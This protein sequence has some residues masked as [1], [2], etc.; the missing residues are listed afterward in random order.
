MGENININPKLGVDI[1]KKMFSRIYG[2]REI[3]I[4]LN[5][6]KHVDFLID[7]SIYLSLVENRKFLLRIAFI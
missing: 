7:I 6:N 2:I 1:V 4:T 3:K 5:C